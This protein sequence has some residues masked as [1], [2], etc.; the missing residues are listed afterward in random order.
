MHAASPTLLTVAAF[1]PAFVWLWYFHRKDHRREPLWLIALVFASGM[2]LVLPVVVLQQR[3]LSWDALAPSTLSELPFPRLLVVTTVVA[4]LVEELAKFGV[5]LAVLIFSREF[6]EPV[7][8]LVYAVAVAMGF[9]A[10]ESWV[11]ADWTRAFSPPAHALFAVFWGYEL[12]QKQFRPALGGWLAVALGLLLSVAV[13]GYWDAIAFYRLRDEA[14][15]WLA[16]VSIFV[17]V[18]GL[19]WW[20]ENRL[21]AAQRQPTEA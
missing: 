11:Q 21:A 17:L 13:H 3:L 4:G 9:T 8:G 12:G 18:V 1:G 5:V 19:Y 7:D 20:M 15:G 16:P 14:D 10:A 2:A 6:E